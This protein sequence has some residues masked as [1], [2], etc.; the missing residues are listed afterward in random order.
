MLGARKGC[1][2]K[3]GERAWVEG[4]QDGSRSSG[5]GGLELLPGAK[6]GLEKAI[7]GRQDEEA[8]GV[9]SLCVCEAF[10]SNTLAVKC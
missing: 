5:G 10:T 6:G 8:S 7:T 2:H 3:Q 4:R 9:L 1:L